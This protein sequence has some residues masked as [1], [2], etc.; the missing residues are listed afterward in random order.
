MGQIKI[1]TY[2]DELNK[3]LAEKKAELEVKEL[4][5]ETYDLLYENQREINFFE[6]KLKQYIGQPVEQ[7]K[8]LI[9][10]EFEGLSNNIARIKFV[11]SEPFQE[12]DVWI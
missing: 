4:N 11:K 10:D 6:E 12:Q 8:Q 5:R 7:N 3:Q 2:V 9:V 1:S